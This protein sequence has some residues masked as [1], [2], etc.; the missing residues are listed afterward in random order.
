MANLSENQMM[1]RLRDGI[2]LPPAWLRITDKFTAICDE[3]IDACLEVTL[4]GRCCPFVVVLKNQSTPKVFKGA[5]VDLLRLRQRSDGLPMF[6]AP[7]LKESQLLELQSLGLSGIDLCG[8]GVIV[9]PDE[10][11]VF[12]TGNKNQFPDSQPTRYAYRGTTSLVARVFLCRSSFSNYAEIVEEIES[13]GGSIAMSTVSKA[14]KRLESD[15]IVT[16]EGEGIRLIQADKLIVRIADDYQPPKVTRS[17]TLT[18]TAPLSE[19][20]AASGESQLVLSGES[21]AKNYA[22]F[23]DEKWPILYTSDLNS[24]SRSLDKRA[25]ESTRFIELEVR[26]TSDVTVYFD[27]RKDNGMLTASPLQSY[28]EL[29]AGNKRQQEVAEQIRERILKKLDL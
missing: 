6:V 9:V 7:Y 29:S 15:L 5:V 8:N 27:A 1:S 19:V 22:V 20:I 18:L 13:R 4:N 24:L 23:G 25:Q 21:S 28:L 17:I 14:I 10:L 26:E 16:R 3:G 12:R 2:S 11:F